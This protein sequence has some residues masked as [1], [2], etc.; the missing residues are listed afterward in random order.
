M[1]RAKRYREWCFT[2]HDYSDDDREH[3]ATKWREYCTFLCYQ[4]ERCTDTGRAHLQGYL[5]LTT[6]RTLRGVKLCMFDTATLTRAH[7][8]D[9]RGTKEE[10]RA[11]CQK[12]DTFDDSA[13][14]R[15]TDFGD[16]EAVPSGRGQGARNDLAGCTAIIRDGGSLTDVALHDPDSFVKYHKGFLA[17]Q[18]LVCAVPRVRD[19]GGLFP[20]LRVFWF[21]GP[22][23]TGKTR[24]AFE[25]AGD[26]AIYS[27]PPGNKWWDGYRGEPV[28][29]LDDF[30]A[31]WFTFGYL[32]RLLD[33][34]PLMLEYKGGMT[35]LCSQTFYITC[36]NH[37][38]VLYE[39]LMARKEGAS[40]Q[41]M[42]R[43]T[44]VREFGVPP[45]PVVPGIESF[46]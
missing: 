34:Y 3:L 39:D 8:E 16:F 30:R 44:E 22:T 9:T 43:I 23:G 27:K 32:L 38:E 29:L 19:E 40:A 24:A 37:P 14:F 31:D 28:I 45:A 33:I 46:N 36:P 2:Y 15:Y 20:A 42:R 35:H 5:C 25:E 6:P 41:L 11:Y 18:Q 7:L 26:Q 17:Y 12:D 4:P 10:A 1:V 13:G 21:Y